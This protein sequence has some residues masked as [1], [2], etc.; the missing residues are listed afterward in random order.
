MRPD[1]D[2]G[3]TAITVDGVVYH[4]VIKN[5]TL[6]VMTVDGRVIVEDIASSTTWDDV[7]YL[8]RTAMQYSLRPDK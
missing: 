7:I 1:I 4:F 3:Y 5:T 2:K 8:I 6:T